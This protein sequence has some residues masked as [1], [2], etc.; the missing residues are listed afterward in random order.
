MSAP[1][2]QLGSGDRILASPVQVRPEIIAR[3]GA[4][5]TS[6]P[7]ATQ[8]AIEALKAGASAMDAAITANAVL[9]LVEPTGAGLGGD[10]FAIVWDP[11]TRS[12]HGYNGSGAS[13]LG[14]DLA[15]VRGR[16]RNGFIPQ[17]GAVS[18]STPGAV[19]GWFALH[20]RFGRRTMAQNLAPAIAYAREG[21]PITP[22]IAVYWAEFMRGAHELHARGRL[23]EVANAEKTFLVDGRPPRAGQLWRNPDLADTYQALAEGGRE[24]FYDGPIARAIDGYMKRIG[25]W[26]SLQDLAAH[27]G[28][29]VEPISASYRGY[30]VWELPPN[31]Q[32][33]AA[34]EMLNVLEGFDL[35]A[36]GA[37]GADALHVMIEAKK[38][39]YADR[40]KFYA[41]LRFADTPVEA[42]M[43]KAY[44]EA[45]RARIRMDRADEA[46]EP[47]APR[48][49]AD[50]VYLTVADRDGMMVS[51]IQSNYFAMGSGLVPDGLGFML[52]NRGALFSVE[53]GAANVF[54]PGKRPFHTII[55]GF[56]TK[57]GEPFLSF[58]VMGGAVQP[59]GHVQILTN[60]IDFGM[61][62]QAAGDA[63]RWQHH[64][65]GTQ[66]DPLT[67]PGGAVS[68][69]SGIAP[70]TIA[71]L[72]RR[73]HRVIPSPPLKGYG[74]Y[75]AILWDRAEGVYR[76]GTEMR[77]DG[78]AAG[79]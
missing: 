30:D 2:G 12:L 18:V 20:E 77:F 67:A 31:T 39:A 35:K 10:L 28:E 13:P 66:D 19:D 58:G 38:L 33:L 47:G 46:M 23:E 8:A 29:W 9:G 73:G 70:E 49:R 37:G 11:R 75:Q 43:S 15:T 41:D 25:G 61:N 57:D 42:L 71:E 24:A 22:L 68:F 79:Y 69:E 5:A 64:G 14:L 27:R 65:S 56:V 54:A 40:A 78:A 76:A 17:F 59:Q 63:A 50:T 45:Q 36:M 21:A 51:L 6:Q 44:A 7:L 72:E 53:E 16:T 4:A 34:I 48:G 55:P 52:Q 32:G 3:N 60:I 62:V 1:A 26:L 74:G